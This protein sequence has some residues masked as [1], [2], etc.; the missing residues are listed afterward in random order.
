MGL[1]AVVVVA[2]KHGAGSAEEGSLETL[3]FSITRI[4]SDFVK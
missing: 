3:E 4:K 2:T 1:C